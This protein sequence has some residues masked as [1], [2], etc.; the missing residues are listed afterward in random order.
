MK[1]AFPVAA[2]GALCLRLEPVSAHVMGALCLFLS[3]CLAFHAGRTQAL[4]EL[5]AVDD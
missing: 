4:E 1:Y 3:L 2:L 5:E